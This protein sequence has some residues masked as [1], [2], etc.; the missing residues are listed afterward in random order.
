M[1]YG[2]VQRTVSPSYDDLKWIKTSY[3]GYNHC[4]LIDKNTGSVLPN[5]VAYV[6]GRWIEMLEPVVGLEKA[7]YY[8]EQLC[9]YNAEQYYL[10]VQDGFSRG[11]TPRLGAIIC[12]QKGQV[13]VQSDGAGHVMIV[14]QINSDGS[15]VC[16]GSNYGG[17]RFYRST[18][19]KSNDYYI[20]SKY[21]FQGFIYPPVEF[22]QYPVTA[23]ERNE[24]VDQI[25]V[26]LAILNCRTGAGTNYERLGFAEQ[27]YYN[28]IQKKQGT[29]SQGNGLMWYEV[30]K[31]KWLAGV[32]KVEYLP[33]QSSVKLYSV[34]FPEVS[35]GDKNTLVNMGKELQLKC[36]VAEL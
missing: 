32:D 29:D 11:K 18:Y 22:A 16:S 9:L 24:K 14:E 36:E 17:T 2:Y 7:K 4:I 6:H 12:W 5:C 33:K 10:Y 8:E 13:G 26:G 19:K 31:D 30:E 23:V 27:G 15:I 1:K 20:G 21:T 28:I 34:L 25:Y 3:G 35:A